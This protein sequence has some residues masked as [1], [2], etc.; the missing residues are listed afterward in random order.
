[1]ICASELGAFDAG[2]TSALM[3]QELSQRIRNL[4]LSLREN[5]AEFADRFGVTQGSVSRWENGSMPDPDAMVRIA[6]LAGVDVRDLLGAAPS[7]ASFVTL[8]QRLMV[9]GAVAAGV[10]REA[11]ESPQEEWEPYTGGVHVKV[12]PSRR[13]G[14]RVEG[15]SMNELYPPGTILDCVSI[16]DT[17]V[18]ESGQRVV[19]IRER[20]DGKLEATVKQ[21]LVDENGRQW[22]LPRSTNP[23]FQTPISIDQPEPGIIETRVIALVVGSYRAE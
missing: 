9:R 3:G 5:Q 20:D 4:R 7:D 13:F 8:G 17:D 11:F 21:Y 16:F 23:S 10:W 1:M 2:L 6:E 12:D 18:P 15:E 14:L 22:L 19:V